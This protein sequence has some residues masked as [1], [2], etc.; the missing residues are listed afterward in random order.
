M[1][2]DPNPSQFD[3]QQVLQSGVHARGSRR[4][5]WLLTAV[6]VLVVLFLAWQWLQPANDGLPGY[7]TRPVETGDITVTVTATGTLEPVN[8]VDV[9]S[10]LSG[11]VD[12]VLVDFNDRVRAGQMLARLNTD[13]LDADVVEARAA[14][15][16]KRAKLKEA[17]ATVQETRLAFER[18][19]KL[20]QRQLC[21]GEEL[22]TARAKAVRARA[23]AASAEAEV[24]VAKATLEG[25]QTEQ[26]KAT[27][28]SPIDGL[29][30]L[31]QIEPGQT[32]AASLQ[33]PVLFT[34]AEDL[35]QME[36]HVAVDEAD[37]GKVAEGQSAEFTVDAYPN[38]RFPATITQVRFAPQT[39]DGVVTYETVLAVDNQDL[40]LR[41]G[42]T[43][44]AVITVQR[45][46]D[47]TLL[48]NAALRFSPPVTQTRERRGGVFGS[49]FPRPRMAGRRSNQN[50]GE[51]QRVW[52]LRQGAP[53]AVAVKT[54][55]SD[56]KVTQ[57]LEGEL[58]PGSEV[59]VDTLGTSK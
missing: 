48:P 20:A 37:V 32:V 41:P 54:G 22:D 9:G 6:V 44:T 11:T 34:L 50:Q 17:Q 18:C 38:R 8:Q 28:H 7:E 27:I 16:S 4:W 33:A 56:G 5:R 49:L 53:V 21:S 10:E 42:M 55:A 13:K 29:V 36:L 24:A 1:A 40:A 15:A 45:L 51:G 31:R 57:L 35:T 59:I 14:L 46:E 52:V 43:A 58:S 2:S 23:V 26:Q 25:K 3:I 39:V 30:L 12:Q 19:E 47:A